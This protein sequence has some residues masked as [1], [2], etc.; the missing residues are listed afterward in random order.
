MNKM[1]DE[2]LT[3]AELDELVRLEAA[4]TPGP[5]HYHDRGGM[6]Y[7]LD[8]PEAGLRGDFANETD[9]AFIAALR[10]AA[11]RL[12]SSLSA[13]RAQTAAAEAERDKL[14]VSRNEA[15]DKIEQLS[16]QNAAVANQNRTTGDA[17]IAL[18]HLMPFKE[19]DEA[20]ARATAAQ[21]A[22]AASQQRAGELEALLREVMIEA[23]REPWEH[24]RR[25]VIG[26]CS[27]GLDD[28]GTGVVAELAAALHAERGGGAAAAGTER[29][30]RDNK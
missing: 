18:S 9:A 5:W 27:R 1:S 8:E 17:V 19:R 12:L 28:D 24:Q 25:K 16:Q 10:N 4:A 29:A 26:M 23:A 3:Q 22:L 20:L 30:P 2:A 7:D 11:P 6:G 15:W 21:T 14:L 13:A